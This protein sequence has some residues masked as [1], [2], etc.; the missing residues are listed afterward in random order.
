MTAL[1][2]VLI[3]LYGLLILT[4]IWGF[5]RLKE[6]ELQ[7]APPLHS[8]S[9]LVVFRNEEAQLKN[10][11]DHFN[12]LDY[13]KEN[14]E[15]ILIDDASTDSSLSLARQ[16]KTEISELNIR[17]LENKPW[18]AAPKKDAL[19]AGVNTANFQWIVT[20]D[21]DCSFSKD[22]LKSYDQY[23]QHNRTKFIAGPVISSSNGSFIHRFQVLDFLS[24]QGATM[25]TFGYDSENTLI[26]PFMCNG[27]NLCYSKEAFQ[28]LKGYDGN[29]HLGSGD[30][31]FLLEKIQRHYPDQV[32]F[33]KSREAIVNTQPKNTWKDLIEQRIRWASKASAYKITFGKITG[34]IV[35]LANFSLV[36]LFFTAFTE[37]V[38]WTFLG[39]IFLIK[40]NIDFIM[41]FRSASFFNQK[42]VLRSFLASSLLYPFFTVVVA[43][44]SL[45]GSY[46]WKGRSFSK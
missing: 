15:I 25:G 4:F 14:F 12:K 8:F 10:L 21:A 24:L 3:L 41:I 1:V 36:I 45:R 16:L 35:L 44:F 33:L 27:A 11:L 40:F 20:T 29:K 42:D 28:D 6:C 5:S 37:A 26:K 2:F 39:I 34:L 13:P 17:I 23:L 31:V 9:V 46:Q 43:L 19:E 18:S 38:S 32:R 30:D 22:W 7:A